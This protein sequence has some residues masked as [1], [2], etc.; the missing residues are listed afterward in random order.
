MSYNVVDVTPERNQ[1]VCKTNSLSP[2]RPTRGTRGQTPNAP[3]QTQG[4]ALWLQTRDE[5]TPSPRPPQPQAGPGRQGGNQGGPQAGQQPQL[6]RRLNRGAGICY[7][8]ALFLG[9][10]DPTGKPPSL[11]LRRM[12]PDM[13]RLLYEDMAKLVACNGRAIGG[14]G[15][16]P[17]KRRNDARTLPAG[18]VVV[19]SGKKAFSAALSQ[20]S[21]RATRHSLYMAPPW[22]EHGTSA[23]LEPGTSGIRTNG[24][25]NER[26]GGDAGASF[27]AEFR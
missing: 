16:R 1:L 23:N 14:R 17:S 20:L 10:D 15:G 18:A 3:P 5:R 13:L 19:P 25:R 21:Y 7:G 8:F 6:P 9:K 2:R 24:L 11:P 26:L 22:I 12:R 4:L 27:Q